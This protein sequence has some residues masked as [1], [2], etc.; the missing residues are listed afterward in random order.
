MKLWPL[1][2]P[3]RVRTPSRTT[4][5]TAEAGCSICPGADQLRIGHRLRALPLAIQ[6]DT[7]GGPVGLIHADFPTDDWQHIEV[8]FSKEDRQ[9]ALWSTLRFHRRYS[10]PVRNVRALLHGHLT[11]SVAQRIANVYFIDTGG[12]RVGATSPLSTL[13]LSG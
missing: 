3:W 2:R 5:S 12:W 11:L 8:P 9:I 6:I 1:S 7:L 13:T 4:G 10:T